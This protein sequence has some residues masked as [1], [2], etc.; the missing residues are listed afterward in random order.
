V[1]MQ[2][3]PTRQETLPVPVLKDISVTGLHAQ[4]AS[5]ICLVHDTYRV[6]LLL[7]F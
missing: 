5:A 1:N 3:A 7:K 2:T 6:D 4:V